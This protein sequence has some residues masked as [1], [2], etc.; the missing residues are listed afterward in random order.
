V[1]V[2]AAALQVVNRVRNRF[3]ADAL[4]VAADL[5]LFAPWIYFVLA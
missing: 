5:C 4:R 3:S 1:L 2:A